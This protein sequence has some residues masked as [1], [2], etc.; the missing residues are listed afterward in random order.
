MK[1]FETPLLPPSP[2]SPTLTVVDSAY[3]G[4]IIAPIALAEDDLIRVVTKKRPKNE[5]AEVFYIKAGEFS[6]MVRRALGAFALIDKECI[7]RV[8]GYY[9]EI[10]TSY[11]DHLFKVSDE[12]KVGGTFD[13]SSSEEDADSTLCLQDKW[14][15]W[16][17]L[18]DEL[19]A[20]FEDLDLLRSHATTPPPETPSTRKRVKR[21]PKTPVVRATVVEAGASIDSAH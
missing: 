4:S 13:E 19:H 6:P 11:I 20:R 7:L 10:I 15:V 12:K 5:V 2:P 1:A 17:R 9:A 3:Q 16:D 18:Y 21:L 8:D 14:L